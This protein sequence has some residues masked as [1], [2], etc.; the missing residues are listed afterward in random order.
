MKTTRDG[1]AYCRLTDQGSG[2]SIELNPEV[3]VVIER[4]VRQK[5]TC[6]VELQLL[7]GNVS[8]TRVLLAGA[9]WASEPRRHLSRLDMVPAKQATIA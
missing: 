7:M 8:G 6:T 4:A 5:K 3:W 1:R 2:L 9:E